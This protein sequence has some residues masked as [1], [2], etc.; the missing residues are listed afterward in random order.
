MLPKTAAAAT[1]PMSEVRSYPQPPVEQM[2][3][4]DNLNKSE[5]CGEP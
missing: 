1:K 3:Y 4:G 5:C 2:F